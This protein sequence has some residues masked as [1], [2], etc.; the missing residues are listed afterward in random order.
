MFLPKKMV[1]RPTVLV[2]FR[3]EE[4]RR[5]RHGE[6]IMFREEKGIKGVRI[7]TCTAIIKDKTYLKTEAT[8]F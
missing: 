7:A 2:L 8:G 3:R 1:V 5:T 4:A 6:I